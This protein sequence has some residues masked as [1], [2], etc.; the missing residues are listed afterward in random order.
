MSYAVQ[1]SKRYCRHAGWLPSRK[2]P[3]EPA[4]P[5]WLADPDGEGASPDRGE[6]HNDLQEGSERI[7]DVREQVEIA[8]GA[9]V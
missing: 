3:S 6:V 7:D 4:H 1:S 2:P 8:E 5:K 9:G